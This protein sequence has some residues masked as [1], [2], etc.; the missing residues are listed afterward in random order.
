MLYI[1]E[2]CNLENAVKNIPEQHR[3]LSQDLFVEG[4]IPSDVTLY[5]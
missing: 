3:F 2:L 4:N 5:R 1:P